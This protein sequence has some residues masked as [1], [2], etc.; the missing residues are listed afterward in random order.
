LFY[1]QALNDLFYW[2]QNLRRKNEKD[3]SAAQSEAQKQAW[4]PLSDENKKW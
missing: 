4:F 3:I 2:I 1:F